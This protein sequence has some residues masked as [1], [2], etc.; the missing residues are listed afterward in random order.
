MENNMEM[1]PTKFTDATLMRYSWSAD[2]P[3]GCV[4]ILHGMAE[5][6]A[7]YDRFAQFICQHG[8]QVYAHDHR[9][10]GQSIST[11]TEPSDTL[12]GHYA[13]QD[14]WNKVLADV[15]AHVQR[16]KAD[17]PELPVL[18]YG[19]SMGSLIL[20]EYLIR[21][22]SN[23]DGALLSGSNGKPD[24]YGK[25]GRWIIKFGTKSMRSALLKPGHRKLTTEDFNKVFK[26]NRSP[27]DWLS[28]D[29]QEVDK[30]ML[31]HCVASHAPH[32]YGAD[33]LDGIVTFSQP[34]RQL[35]IRKDI[36]LFVFS[37][38]LDPVGKQSAG[39]KN[40]CDAYVDAGLS[41]VSYKL[42]P[43]ARHEMLN[44]TNRDEVHADLLEW[45]TNHFG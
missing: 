2:S 44:E 6:A 22:S 27:S 10:H 5:H 16:I 29:E 9:G 37:G 15:E 34:S 25:I 1:T 36:P 31:I 11:A 24:P 42:Y 35:Q 21:H 43:N 8:W 17:H 26:P 41:D 14:G 40:L 45:L 39:V 13:D 7:R 28:R 18:V 32:S 12:Q 38:A 23:I 4:L 3:K 20:Q 19:H 33:L 30:Y